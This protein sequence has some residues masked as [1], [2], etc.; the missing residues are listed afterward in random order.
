VIP[1]QA[2]AG[3]GALWVGFALVVR[4]RHFAMDGLIA[5]ASAGIAIE[6]LRRG[7]R[8]SSGVAGLGRGDVVLAALLAA[9]VG[10]RWAPALVAASALLALLANGMLFKDR[11]GPAPFGPALALVGLVTV[12]TRLF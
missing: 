6:T 9:W 11:Q 3:I 12:G 2:L 1:A 5:A 4:D 7:Y 8:T 10:W